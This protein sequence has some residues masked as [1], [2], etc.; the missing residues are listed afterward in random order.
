VT[1]VDPSRFS[2]YFSSGQW[3][4]ARRAMTAEMA[5]SGV[6]APLLSN[7]GICSLALGEVD[8]ALRDFQRACEVRPGASADAI[9]VGVANWWAGCYERAVEAWESALT[10]K[11]V[12]AAGGVEAPAFLL[13]AARR[14]KGIFPE[15]RSLA[16]LRDRWEPRLSKIWPGPIA[17]F[18]LGEMDLDTFLV[19]QTF[20]DPILE[21]RRL[22]KAHFWV[23][24]S[25][26]SQARSDRSDRYG[27]H[28]RS[29]AKPSQQN[30][31]CIEDEFW[32]ARA[33]L[34]SLGRAEVPS[35][36]PAATTPATSVPPP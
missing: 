31:A 9:M 33:E 29:S 6:A 30:V 13:F 25:L 5:K 21:E 15:E 14:R 35:S 7:R 16:L 36:S 3:E 12:D 22:C 11:W 26:L 1:A 10:S 34:E 28:L 32:L 20:I 24:T 18:L 8:V 2:Y 4:L 17:G 19:R 27:D 23:A